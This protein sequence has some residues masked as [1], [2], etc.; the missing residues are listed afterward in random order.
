MSSAYINLLSFGAFFIIVAS[1]VV[2][3]L[4]LQ[5]ILKYIDLNGGVTRWQII[6][7][8]YRV[9]L[10]RVLY[11]ELP[12]EILVYFTHGHSAK[13]QTSLRISLE[14]LPTGKCGL[15][16]GNCF[17]SELPSTR[18]GCEYER[19]RHTGWSTKESWDVSG[20]YLFI[21][22]FIYLFYFIFLF[23]YFL[24]ECLWSAK[25]LRIEGQATSFGQFIFHRNPCWIKP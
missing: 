19:F 22:L 20:V 14:P 1:I 13:A 18:L 12:R 25:M 4:F 17:R 24:L 6:T 10:N 23:F 11:R 5:E 16:T 3:K 21:Y 9:K 2:R 8:V 15:C 7:I